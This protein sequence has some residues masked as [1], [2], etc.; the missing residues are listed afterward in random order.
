[1]EDADLQGELKERRAEEGSRETQG[2]NGSGL[3]SF[4]VKKE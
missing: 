2:G 1:M 4:L 3:S